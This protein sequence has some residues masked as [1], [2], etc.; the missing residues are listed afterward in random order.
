MRLRKRDVERLLDTYDADPVAA[1]TVAL[2]VALDRP[3]A[4][5]PDLI[6]DLP[7][8]EALAENDSSAMDRLATTLN[9]LRVAPAAT[10]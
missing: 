3:D 2:R 8:R 9:E 10:P 5:Y 4:S 1:L 7:E 6:A